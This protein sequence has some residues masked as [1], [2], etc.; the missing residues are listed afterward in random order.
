MI[1]TLQRDTHQPRPAQS[2][3]GMLTVNGRGR[4]HTIEHP[5]GALAAGTYRLEQQESEAHG[6]HFMLS[7]P[8]LGVYRYP[9]ELP[10][11]RS[12]VRALVLLQ[13]ANWAHELGGSIA[14]G[15]HRCAPRANGNAFDEWMVTESRNALNELRLLLGGALDLWLAIQEGP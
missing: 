4:F 10:L 9:A 14:I 8:S 6:K 7:A 2:L 5:A 12:D 1:L 15:K 3:L 13:A 11:G